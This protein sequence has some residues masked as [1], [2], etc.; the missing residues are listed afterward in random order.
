MK[1]WVRSSADGCLDDR[2]AVEPRPQADA[3]RDVLGVP[4][5]E[6]QPAGLKTVES[7]ACTDL[8]DSI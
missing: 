2:V 6:D 3:M 4:V 5:L 7:A 1:D 8:H